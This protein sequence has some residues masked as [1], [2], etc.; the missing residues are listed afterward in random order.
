MIQLSNGYQ[1]KGI[2]F[3]E[4]LNDV[5]DAICLYVMQFFN[6]FPSLNFLLQYIHLV[7]DS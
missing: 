6:L 3:H 2:L 1:D 4:N 7:D 5:V